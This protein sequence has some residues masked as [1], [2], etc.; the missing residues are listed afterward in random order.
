MGLQDDTGQSHIACSRKDKNNRAQLFTG[1]YS[2]RTRD[3]NGNVE[4]LIYFKR[5]STLK[6][7][8]S[9]LTEV[10]KNCDSD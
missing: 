7:V 9:W 6:S 3:L 8:E 5:L 2:Y 1:S 10:V 4:L